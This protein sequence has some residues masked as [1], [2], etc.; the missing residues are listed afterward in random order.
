MKKKDMT[1]WGEV[2]DGKLKINDQRMFKKY[3]SRLKGIVSLTIKERKKVRT[4]PQNSLYWMWI[5]IIADELG[6][7]KEE[8]HDTFKSMYNCEIKYVTNKKTGEV[9]ETKIVRSSTVMNI[10]EFIEYMDKIERFASEAGI[11]LPQPN[12]GAVKRPDNDFGTKRPCTPE[13]EKKQAYGAENDSDFD[14]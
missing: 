11:I 14:I 12:E 10:V 6:Y 1:F 9:K 7:D 2:E 8:M 13:R 4:L 5:T 3:I